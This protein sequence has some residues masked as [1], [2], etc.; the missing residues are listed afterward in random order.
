MTPPTSAP[1]KVDRMGR[2]RNSSKPDPPRRS[3]K[4]IRAERLV[5]QRRKRWYWVFGV[6][7]LIAILSWVI[8]SSSLLGVNQVSVQGAGAVSADQ[9]R[10]ASGVANGT[11]LAR[12]DSD[13]I[14]AKVQKIPAIAT[15]AVKL[16]WPHEVIITV[17]ERSPVV[18]VMIGGEQWVV[19]AAGTPYLRVSQLPGAKISGVPAL[20]VKSP[21]PN[22]LA[23][24]S[25]VQIIQAVPAQLRASVSSI[26][27][28]SPA[29]ISLKLSDG[30]TIIWG[31]SDQSGRKSSLLPA[32]LSHD[33]TVFDI[34]SPNQ[35][36]I[37]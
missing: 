26:D 14:A 35:V 29:K 4:S 36:V 16:S 17:V 31:T 5:L 24:R 20:K 13:A 32:L 18:T 33:G 10:Q 15:A 30:R 27:A 28:T 3:A 6:A 2:R 1:T 23:T 37:S 21:G 25:A 11:P 34:S 12:L 22:H 19:D 7:A 9:I 8:F